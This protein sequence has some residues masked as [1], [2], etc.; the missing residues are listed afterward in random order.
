MNFTINI[1]GHFQNTVSR[2]LLEMSINLGVSLV[3]GYY[4]GIY[5]VLL[6]T[7]IA[8]LYRTNEMI[9]YTNRRILQRSPIKT[10]AVYLSNNI[11]FAMSQAT[12]RIVFDCI[13]IDSYVK[14]IGVRLICSVS[15]LIITVGIQ[16][17]IFCTVS[18]KRLLRAKN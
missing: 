10:Y 9:I 14:F 2:A 16:I 13:L 17:L 3:G 12:F 1:S 7:V 6:G 8:L 11:S 18:K 4:W 5:G 15:A